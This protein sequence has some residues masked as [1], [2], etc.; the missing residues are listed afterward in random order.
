LRKRKIPVFSIVIPMIIGGAAAA[1]VHATNGSAINSAHL[2]SDILFGM[3]SAVLFWAMVC[4]LGNLHMFT[5]FTYGFK[6][7]HALLRGNQKNSAEMKEDYLAYRESRP[8]HDNTGLVFA[9][10]AVLL[11]LSLALSCI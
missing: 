10:G 8:V 9:A 11:A 2:P 5:S 6:Q 3:A 4:S 1:G 7:L